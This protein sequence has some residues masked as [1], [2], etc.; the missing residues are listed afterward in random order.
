M[1]AL[2]IGQ[3]DMV[4]DEGNAIAVVGM[5]C[6]FPGAS[7]VDD[8]WQ[9]LLAG[10]ESFSSFS[11]EEL[12]AAGVSE[13][14][15]RNPNY[16][17]V[18]PV[19]DEIDQ[20]DA[21]FFGISPR[22]AEILDP[23]HRVLLETCHVAIQRAGYDGCADRLRVG[24]FAG[25]RN[26]EY[27]NSNLSANPSLKRTVGEMALI[28]S[29][30]TDYLATSVAYRLNLRGPAV[31]SVTACSTSL[32]NV[33]L[34]CQSLRVGECDV[35]LAAGVEIAVPMIRGYV[36]NEGGINSPDGRVRPFDANARGTVFGNGC[37][38]VVLKRM[39]DALA[40]RDTISAVIL[41][42]AINNDGSGKSD[43]ASPSKIGQVE[44]IRAALR[45]SG[46]DP[47]TIGFVE[48]HGTGTMVGDPIEIAALTDAYR[49]HTQRSGYCAV[50]SVKANVGHLGAA[51]GI[52]GF[53]KAARCV[54]DGVLPASLNFDEP[55][56]AIDFVSSPFYVNATLGKW[57]DVQA[58]RRAGVS[59]FGVGGTNAHV[60]IESPP[61]PPLPGPSRRPYQ[62]L[63]ISARTP[64]ALA[65]ASAEIAEHLAECPD[66]LADIGFTLNLGR[67]HHAARRFLVASDRAEAASK[68]ASD[69]PGATATTLPA[70]TERS[71]AFLFPGQGAQYPGMARGLYDR[72]PAFASHID[73]FASVLADSH[74]LNLLDLLFSEAVGAEDRLGQ[75]A[76]T[77]PAMF[78][79]EYAL[80]RL[81]QA[82]GVTPAAMAG[83]S[84]GEFVAASLAGVID[85][86]DAVRLVA[87]RGALM[88]AV[89]A[90]SMLAV[91]LPEELLLPM[92]PPEVDLAAVNGPGVC[93][94]SGQN[95]DIAEMQA[96]FASQGIGARRL[97]TSHAFHSQMMEP[98]LDD[99]RQRVAQVD[100]R[101]PKIPYVSNLT[102][103]WIRDEEAVDPDYWAS[104]LRYC[105]RFSDT[106]SLLI[107]TGRYVFAEVGPGQALTGL[108]GAYRRR[109]SS[110]RPVPTAVATLRK[111]NENRDDTEVALEALGRIWAAGGPV[112]WAR[113]WSD[114]RRSR[115]PLPT[116]PYERRR[117]W[118]DRIVS[119]GF[120]LAGQEEDVGPFF[121][122]TW[123]E[124][125]LTGTSRARPVTD[126][127]WVVFALPGDPRI[128]GLVASLRA[129]GARVAVA[130]PSD[131]RH[132]NAAD[133]Y[134]LRVNEPADYAELFAEI[135]GRDPGHVQVV[136]AW[137]ADEPARDQSE[138]D[139]AERT[140]DHGF[141]SVL[142][143]MQA[144]ARL[145]PAVPVDACVV[146]SRMQDVTGTGDIE[147]ARAAV[148]G[149]VKAAAKEFDRIT[150]RSVDI[151]GATQVG[152]TSA[153]LL[154]E[155]TC[156]DSEQV[157]YRGRK[158]WT[159]SYA[160]TTPLG[161]PGSPALLKDQ[162]VYLITGGLGGLG[163]VL[164]KQLAQLV[165][166]RLVLVGRT[167]LPERQSWT[168]LLAGTAD[169]D[170]VARAVRSVLDIE[171]A[172]GTV[173]ALAGDVT[174]ELQMR[175]VEA[176]ISAVFGA[177]DGV[178]HLA[179]VAGGGMLEARARAAAAA[180]L[181]PKVAGTYVLE[182]VFHP[183]LFVLYSSTAVIAGDFGLGDYAGANAV[184]DAF[185]QSRWP[186][187]R[188][189]VSVNWPPWN[190][191]GMAS[192]IRGPSVLR[193]L[194][195]GPPSPVKHPMLRARRGHSGDVVAF[196][197]ELDPALW[198]FAEHKMDGTP[199]MPGTGI[200]EL[201]RAAYQEVT[202]NATAD[203]RDLM[204]P[205][206]L[207]ATPGIEAR[208]EF[209][210]TAD[211]GYS[212]SVTGGLPS[213][214]PEQFA[215]GRV[216]ALE[217][218]PAPHHDLAAIRAGSWHDTT[219]E[220]SPHV[221]L[222]Q[223]GDRWNS[224]RSRQS[225][226]DVD[227][228]Y[229]SLSDRFAGDLNQFGVHPAL[230]DVAG[231]MGMNR[232]GDDL[233]LPFG[234]DRIIVRGP[235]PAVCH[236]LIR[237]LD[238]TRGEL[239]RLDLTII[240]KDGTEV[241]AA[242]GYSLLRVSGNRTPDAVSKLAAAGR[243]A[244]PGRPQVAGSP[245][246]ALIRESN[247]ESS[248]SSAE[249][250]EALRIMLA[251]SLGPQVILCPGG[252]AERVRRAGR[253]T[254]S[255]L[256]ERLASAVAG[257]GAARNVATPYV[258]PQTDAELT[259]AELWRDAI[260]VDQV[261]IDDDFL[262]LGGDSL[263]A[264]QLV[265]RISRRLKTDIS[266]AQLFDN[267]T[268][269]ALAASIGQETGT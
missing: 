101:S 251:D 183:A 258:P 144:V 174:D 187:G 142:T 199:A 256:T 247:A 147:P 149:L 119:D 47:D 127:H 36:Y 91:M 162:G 245:V 170:Q 229:L 24:L 210:R 121:V 58:P 257:D 163:L 237:H 31:T 148:L 135:A 136:H 156:A 9:N 117:F 234:Y 260:G 202:G 66:E 248:V 193:D 52:A 228:L 189:V 253:I 179:A 15:L 27:V 263:L 70:G 105:V 59:A 137:T 60:I 226:A 255:V 194:E 62:L 124:S 266:V 219:P 140:L 167:G 56:P 158:R 57:P 25:S 138:A 75:T 21:A 192:E 145:L 120:G 217:E 130:E 241:L 244:G 28:I 19:I 111:A 112:D 115:V 249:G 30:Q 3:S 37:G 240:G 125:P 39:N 17:K 213:R 33:H 154:A 11:E 164:A 85:A 177:V 76:V 232:P 155:L 77:Q 13:R 207:T 254:R 243:L 172:G 65:V 53:I 86:D 225:A 87:D 45:D 185:A 132:A 171:E 16:V 178:F 81:L 176:E 83:H 224:I 133:H 184:L 191:V 118:I 214:P 34:A 223:F 197:V 74:H 14:D 1:R 6:R 216:Y 41:G 93:V 72:E 180:V 90:G 104:H 107:D 250:S 218:T 114:E 195:L 220:F 264:V 160:A 200:V 175:A 100:L 150:C 159:W 94:I 23:Q 109:V 134:V 113:F 2:P 95:R 203:I 7:N 10:K 230:L 82:W 166:A 44:V 29:N 4:S 67:S 116:Y 198:V 221:G 227:F 61:P 211:G 98:V 242:E 186:S 235:V 12:L 265:G 212:V 5:A 102:G 79:V 69:L 50:A 238:D 22:E 43:F 129:A 68:L 92:L 108:V 106:L 141:F 261:G 139:R 73:A 48:A 20:L 269:R 157:A 169:D 99:F 190:E 151:D 182:H 239:A 89:P 78:A 32:V 42:T 126:T 209:R 222:M 63:T 49:G 231:A 64:A 201:I 96:I 268:V 97:R 262:D 35:A 110:G 123:R 206:L 233:Y 208:A 204:F 173:L 252:I 168:D 46:V 161:S 88:Q 103:T 165:R 8:F 128:G 146:T 246:M 131:N 143:I 71:I 196:D 51:A 80:A 205:S 18:A 40:D 38:V 267:R 181:G 84:V 153:Q 188:H 215:R 26:N 152:V 122:P 54:Q 259:I 236:S 55:N